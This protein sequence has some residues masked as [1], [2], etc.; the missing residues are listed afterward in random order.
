MIRKIVMLAGVCF[1]LS[2]KKNTQLY[3]NFVNGEAFGTTFSVQCIDV[4]KIDYSKSYDSLITVINTS[5]STY[6]KDS[7][8][9]KINRG[10]TTVVVDKHFENVFLASKRLY[11]ATSGAFDPTIGVLVNAWDFGPEGKVIALDS[12]KIDSLLHTVGINKVLLKDGKIIKNHSKTFIDFN[13]L[14][15]GYAVDVFADFLESKG[16]SNYLV[17]I[18]GEI[19]AKGVN[20]IKQKPWKI[21]VEDP[22]F[23]NTQSYSKIIDLQDQAM[24]TSGS[25]RKFKIDDNGNRYA[26]IIDTKTGYPHKSNVLSVSVL[27]ETCMEADA[28]ATAFMSMGLKESKNFLATHTNLKVFF[29]YEDD[30]K[31]LKTLSVNGFPEN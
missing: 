11:D 10:D 1:F 4:K 25:Y 19:R 8:I 27:A 2:C 20:S 14:A 3:Q 16:H 6:I 29:I 21:G 7:D 9:S 24:A 12:L 28:Y 31:T 17:E 26:H 13:A 22:N 15:K 23:D 5:M 30:Q 18:G